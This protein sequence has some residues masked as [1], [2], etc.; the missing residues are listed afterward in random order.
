MSDTYVVPTPGSFIREELEARGWSQRDLAFVLGCTEQAVNP[1]LSGKRGIS[2]DMAKAL[3]DAFDVAPE[4]FLNLQ[5][6]YDLQRAKVPDPDVSKRAKLQDRYPVREMIKR[7]WLDETSAD[8]LEEQ[9]CRFFKVKDQQSIPYFTHAAKKT[10]YDDTPP[11]QLVWLFRVRQLAEALPVKPYSAKALRASLDQL[12][13]LMGDPEESRHVPR[14]L[15]ECGVRF[16]IV[17]PLQGSKIDGVAFWIDASPVIG[18]SLRFDRI[19][20]F[21]FVLRHEIEHILRG[22]GK[23][24]ECLDVDLV[25]S[26]DAATEEEEV[27]A[28]AAAQGFGVSDEELNGFLAR[29]YPLLAEDTFC[30]FAKILGVHPGIAV[31]RAQQHL[32]KFNFLRHLLVKIREYVCSSAITD[33]WG[34]LVH[35]DL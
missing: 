9:L 33:G 34:K 21:W 16:I 3:G 13:L 10:H 31:G 8:L 7:G 22:H 28:N 35:L 25:A 32:N 23:T 12:K 6:T 1:I 11:P 27:I 19:D 30:S 29:Y 26:V 15:A 20:N 4:F 24:K 2:P 5:K 18:M 14:V 17:E